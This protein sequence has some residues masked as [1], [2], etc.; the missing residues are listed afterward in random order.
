MGYHCANLNSQAEQMQKILIL[1]TI[2]P[3]M[4]VGCAHKI[5]IQQG[6]VVTQSQLEK[7]RVGL[8][9][10]QVRALLGSPLLT[11]AFHPDRWD[12]YYS[13]S[14]GSELKKRYRLTL[15]FSGEQLVRFEKEGD[16]PAEEYQKP[17]E[18]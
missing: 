7:L 2:I 6:N 11:D 1:L 4:L 14:R 15:H 10:R 3:L 12:Y 16:F 17:L 8:D 5:E 18:D 9:K 13:I